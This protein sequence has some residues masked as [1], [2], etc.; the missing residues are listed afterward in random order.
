MTSLPARESL[1]ARLRDVLGEDDSATMMQLMRPD[2]EEIATRADIDRLE[3]GME[4]LEARMDKL[5]GRMGKL[6]GRMDKLDGRMDK[7]DD[8]LHDFHGAL[9][10]QTWNFVLAS[11]GSVITVGGLAF[12]AAALI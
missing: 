3:L 11:T 2:P 4:R 5:D 7:F 10:E 8:R 6:D 1:Y 12:A 9:R